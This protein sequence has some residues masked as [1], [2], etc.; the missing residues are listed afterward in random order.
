VNWGPS[1]DHTNGAVMHVFADGHV[2]AITDTVDPQTY[3]GLTTRAGGEGIDS[4]LI[5]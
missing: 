2:Q 1:S 5:R 4:S 3:L